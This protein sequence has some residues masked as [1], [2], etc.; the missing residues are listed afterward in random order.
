[1]MESI[2]Q[3]AI[4]LAAEAAA[5]PAQL[6]GGTR[7]LPSGSNDVLAD[8]RPRRQRDPVAD[9]ERGGLSRRRLAHDVEDRE[10]TRRI[11]KRPS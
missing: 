5:E 2:I 4:D 6:K 7:A 8:E 3:G 10:I 11:A 9:R 1:V